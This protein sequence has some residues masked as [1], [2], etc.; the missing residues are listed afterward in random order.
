MPEVS[1][2][3]AVFNCEAYVEG[4]IRSITAQ[5]ARDLEIIVIDDGSTDGTPAVLKRLAS[6]DNRIAVYWQPNSGYAGIARNLGISHATG[7]YLAFLDAD[8]L[9]H[10]NRIERAL[11]GFEK[12]PG[13]DIVFHD[14]NQFRTETDQHQTRSFLQQTGFLRRASDYLKESEPGLYVCRDDFYTFISLDY[15]PFHTSSIMFRRE[16]LGPTG[17][18]FREDIY[19]GEDGDLWL[20]LTKDH[21]VVFLNEVLSYYRQWP[22]GI[23]RDR[24]RHLLAT[25]KL[26]TDNLERGRAVFSDQERQQYRSKIAHQLFELGYEYFCKGEM[27]ECRKAYKRSLNFTFSIEASRAYLKSFLPRFIVKRYRHDV[28]PSNERGLVRQ[29]SGQVHLK[30]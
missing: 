15:I 21:R 27:S 8:D 26:H 4:C 28:H 9:Y 2:I 25:I 10:P 1:V 30:S 18:F 12:C 5:T 17:P 29:D 14:H 16:L 19:P 24:V 20:R 13:V 6:T 7:R 3:V 23:S 22:G 11:S